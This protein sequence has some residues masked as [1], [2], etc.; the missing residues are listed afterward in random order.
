MSMNLTNEE[1]EYREFLKEDWAKDLDEYDWANMDVL[2]REIMLE[3]LERRF[4]QSISPF[5]KILIFIFRLGFIVAIIS[6]FLMLLNAKDTL[7]AEISQITLWSSIAVV[8]LCVTSFSFF[9]KT[10]RRWKNFY[11]F[12]KEQKMQKHK[13]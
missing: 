10:N 12:Y 6:A 9:W 13:S 3:H 5:F 7:I 11:R 8:L 1:R 4:K 2:G